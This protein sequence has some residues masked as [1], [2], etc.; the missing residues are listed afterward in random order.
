MSTAPG[1]ITGL[2][3]IAQDDVLRGAGLIDPQG[4]FNISLRDRTVCASRPDLNGF[5]VVAFLPASRSVL[6][7]MVARCDRLGIRHNGI[8]E[9]PAGALLDVPDP[10]GTVLRFYHFTD[11][12]DGFTGVRFRHGRHVGNYHTPRLA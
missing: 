3:R 9:T 6:D 1:G 4:R 11:P 7:D 10:D 2:D 5:D 12:T 8:Q